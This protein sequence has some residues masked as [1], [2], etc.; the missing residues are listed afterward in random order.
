MVTIARERAK[1]VG[2]DTIATFEDIDAESYLYPSSS[3][4]AV[5]SRW[6]LMFLPN[7]TPTLQKIRVSLVPNGV[8]AAAV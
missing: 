6:G 8:L 2:L 7:L 3:F 5:T 4:N 1:G